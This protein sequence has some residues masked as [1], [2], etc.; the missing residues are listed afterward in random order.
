MANALTVTVGT[1]DYTFDWVAQVIHIEDG[2]DEVTAGDLKDAIHDAQDDTQGVSY[3]QI[4]DFFNPVTLTT[5]A[6]TF[7]NVVLRNQWRIDSMSTSGTLTVG[8]GNV[9]NAN[10]GIDIFT[11][12]VLVNM[13]N[14]TS[15]AGVFIS[16]VKVDEIHEDRG[17][18][19]ANPKTVTEN[20][21][22][23][24]YDEDTTNVSKTV[25]KVG[26]VTTITR[27]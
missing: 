9:V 2:V 19:S 20:T 1:T 18:N 16:S 4:A 23:T 15:Q 6:D 26:S 5:T 22:G 3:E 8:T 12:N 25:V 7:L 13:V 27:V 21:A 17:L 10:N 24:D 11:P 14:N